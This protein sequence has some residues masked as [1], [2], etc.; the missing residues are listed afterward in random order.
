MNRVLVL[1]AREP[2]RQ[3]REKGLES[4]GAAEL[5]REFARGWRDAARLV[6]A[7]LILAAPREDRPAWSTVF[8]GAEVG[9]L[10]Q[11]G[12]S[13]GARLEDAARR[14]ALAGGQAV[15]VGGDVAPSAVALLEA[16][17]ALESGAD[18]AISPAPD[19]GFS[20]VAL[21]REDFDLLRG[22]RERRRTVLRD[23]LRALAAR[24]R[25]VKLLSPAADVD[26]RGSLRAI[27]SRELLPARF[28]PLARQSLAA[29]PGFSPR[30]E[31]ALP[32]LSHHGPSDLRGPP[33]PA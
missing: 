29:T 16:F 33:L 12:T 24:R 2:A 31:S 20:L 27:L 1:F 30:S 28:V 17:L 26:G 19:G 23:L 5:F 25:A 14:A 32:R 10:S 6:G 4:P 13:I 22:V 18:A 9:W 21:A 11:R 8:D 7:E 3:A 15:L